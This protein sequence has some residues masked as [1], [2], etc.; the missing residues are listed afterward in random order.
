MPSKSKNDKRTELLI[1]REKYKQQ[2][3]H[4]SQH[5]TQEV[6][7]LVKTASLTAG[8]VW[9]GFK[10]I[11]LFTGKSKKVEKVIYKDAEKA[12]RSRSNP[13]TEL[14]TSLFG[15]FFFEMKEF[16]LGLLRQIIM[17]FVH[18]KLYKL[19]Q[20]YNKNNEDNQSGTS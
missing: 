7:S 2:F 16:F 20:K 10:I 13:I 12:S 4:R 3:V 15:A 14:G 8:G 11:G 6:M 19:N 18:D 5:T 17:D 9:A 1:L